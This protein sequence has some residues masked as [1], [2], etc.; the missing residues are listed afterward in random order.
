MRK[1]GDG[2]AQLVLLDHGL[3][4]SIGARERVALAN[5]YKAIVLK[6]EPA[7]QMYSED[8]NVKGIF[9]TICKELELS[10]V[11]ISPNCPCIDD[12]L[13]YT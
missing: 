8:L 6:D 7:M 4:E 11:P 2:E 1:G 13:L 12:Y 3:Y 10:S 5:M 9:P